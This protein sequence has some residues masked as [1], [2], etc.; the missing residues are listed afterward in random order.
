[1]RPPVFAQIAE[2]DGPVDIIFLATKAT[3]LPGVVIDLKPLMKAGTVIVSLQNGLCA[4]IIAG[5]VGTEATIGCVIGWGATLHEPG[6]MEMTSKGGF[7]IG[8]LDGR[9]DDVLLGVQSTLAEAA[10]TTISAN[11]IG[12]LYGK[13]II[14]SCITTLG[15]ICGQYL[16]PMLRI[17][18]AR[19]MFIGI[20]GEGMDVAR[21]MNL[22]VEPVS[23]LDFGSFLRGT[24]PLARLKRHALIRLIGFKYRKLKSS[25]LQ[26]LERGERTEIDFLNGFIASRGRELGVRTPL[27]EFLIACVKDI[28]AG[29]R[30]IGLSNFDDSFLEAFR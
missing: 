21:A 27:N 8:R 11:I 16:G 5:I 13:L 12:H 19:N 1:V 24:G 23:R 20:I 7:I 10:P 17:R 2:I 26:S 28:E 22:H 18:K 30:K 15:A 3:S 14:N 29:R 9:T 6:V 4:D 25:S